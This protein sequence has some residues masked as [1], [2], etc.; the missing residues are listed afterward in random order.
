MDKPNIEVTRTPAAVPADSIITVEETARNTADGVTHSPR[1]HVDAR[2]LALSTL[3][4][5]AFVF[6]LQWAHKFFIPLVFG[7]FIAYTLSPVVAWFERLKIPRVIGASI[8]MLIIMFGAVGLGSRL[9]G[10][11][12]SIVDQLPESTEKL[13]RALSQVKNTGPSTIEQMQ[14]AASAL[15]RATSQAAG[16]TPPQAKRQTAETPAFQIKQWIWASSIGAVGVIGQATMVLFLVF[17]LLLSGDTFKRKLV[18]LTGPSLS[19]K[20]I[21]VNILTDIN[22]SIQNYMFMLLVTNL[23][24]GAM[25]YVAFRLI[26]LENA[27]AWAVAAA[28]LHVIPYFGPLLISIATGL[29]AFMQFGTFSMMAAAAGISLGVATIVGTFVTTWM[30]GRIAKMNAAAVFIGLL[31]W[32]WIWGVWGLL[33]G[34][35]II[36]IVKVISE[37]V[38]GLQSV[39]EL[40]GE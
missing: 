39:A 25:M 38:E 19:K 20:K 22:T 11:F 16:I 23:M 9:H 4:T 15:E 32:G 35:P 21:T 8:V 28:L 2:G 27:G 14:A 17:F 29:A 12:Q 1:I 33:L 18:K 30:T 7:I 6:A 13:S 36:V 31:F 3:A 37:H 24:L 40:L 5:L 26:G 10:Q 34:I